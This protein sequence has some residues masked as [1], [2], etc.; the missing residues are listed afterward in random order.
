MSDRFVIEADKTVVGM[1][2][3]STDGFRFFTS[4]PYFKTLEG[5][6]FRRV[7]ALIRRVE[8]LAALK[9]RARAARLVQ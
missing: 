8:E 9:R 2:V 3:R 6:R 1:A 4:N 5:K 7:R